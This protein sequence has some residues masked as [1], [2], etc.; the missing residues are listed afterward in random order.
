MRPVAS[1]SVTSRSGSDA[2]SGIP[3]TPPPD[4]TSTIGPANPSTTLEPA[5]RVVEQRCASLVDVLDRRQAWCFDEGFE[6]AVKQLVR[7]AAHKG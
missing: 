7:V 1:S 5:Q 6:P 4:P 3:G 2:A